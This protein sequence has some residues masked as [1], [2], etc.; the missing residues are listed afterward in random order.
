MTTDWVDD[1]MA[2]WI[3]DVPEWCQQFGCRQPVQT[4]CPL[5]RSYF[6]AEHDELYPRR[7]HDCLRGKAE[8]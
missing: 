6:C 4:W 8:E 2:G 1:V 3:E 5:C 7:R